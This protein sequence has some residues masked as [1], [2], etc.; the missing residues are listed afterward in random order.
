MSHWDFIRWLLDLVLFRVNSVIAWSV[1]QDEKGGQT[2]ELLVFFPFLSFLVSSW[3]DVNLHWLWL[4]IG[5]SVRLALHNTS[6]TTKLI[7]FIYII[8]PTYLSQI[9]I[10]ERYGQSLYHIVSDGFH[11]MVYWHMDLCRLR[12]TDSWLL[13]SWSP[14]PMSFHGTLGLH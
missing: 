1:I 11:F 10:F 7:A 13:N 8:S 14:W 12:L 6:R 3:C 5:Q 2:L 4:I 9:Y